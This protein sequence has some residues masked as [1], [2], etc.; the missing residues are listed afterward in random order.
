MKSV[1]ENYLILLINKQVFSR[2]LNINV[3]FVSHFPWIEVEDD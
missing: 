2:Q 1:S 3:D